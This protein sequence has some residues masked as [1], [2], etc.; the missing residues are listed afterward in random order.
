MWTAMLL[1]MQAVTPGD[2]PPSLSALTR[3]DPAAVGDDIVVCADHRDRYRL[4]LPAERPAPEDFVDHARG[5]AVLTPPG[6]CGMFAGEHRCRK[7]EM[8]LYGYG[9]GRDPVTVLGR[10]ARTVVDADAD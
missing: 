3:C 6:R 9:G 1:A 4:P 2:I 5:I 7:A 8:R 10:L